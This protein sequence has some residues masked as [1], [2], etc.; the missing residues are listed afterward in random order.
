[1]PVCLVSAGNDPSAHMQKL[2]AQMGSEY[3]QP[4]KRIMEINP[5]HPLFEKML[6][7]SPDQ[8]AKWSEILYAQALLNEGSSIPD[9]VKFSQQVAEL[10]ISAVH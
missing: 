4:V 5:K 10:M 3:N 1:T 7:A 2:M 6:K 9:P 8:Q